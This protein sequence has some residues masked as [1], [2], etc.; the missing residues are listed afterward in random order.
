[1]P[2]D[3]SIIAS[4]P[5]QPWILF[6][7]L[8]RALI[9]ISL[10]TLGCAESQPSQ[11]EA[12]RLAK[13]KSDRDREWRDAQVVAQYENERA[14]KADE[15]QR[16]GEA[17]RLADEHCVSALRNLTYAVAKGKLQAQGF[18][19]HQSYQEP[20]AQRTELWANYIRPTTYAYLRIN[21]LSDEVERAD[22]KLIRDLPRVGDSYD[23]AIEALEENRFRLKETSESRNTVSERWE[24]EEPSY[25]TKYFSLWRSASEYHYQSTLTD[26]NLTTL[27]H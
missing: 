11:Y 14:R 4:C 27:K 8:M 19:L 12:D 20:D 23:W 18:R 22:F 3:S 9:V 25:E 26:V 15:S 2:S 10:F 24:Y 13:L 6:G 5:Y 7:V 21:Q 1:M 17:R 16:R